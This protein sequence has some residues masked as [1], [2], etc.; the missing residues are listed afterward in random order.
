[1]DEVNQIGQLSQYIQEYGPFVV[2]LAVFLLL[3]LMIIIYFIKANK[4][5]TKASTEMNS[6][7]ITSILNDYMAKNAIQPEKKKLYDEKNIVDIFVKLNKSLKNVCETAS[8][9][10]NSD[11]TAIYV[12]HNGS[13]ASHGLPFFKMSCISEWVSKNSNSNIKMAEHSAMPL[14]LFDTIVS[15][16]YDDSQYR[17]TIGKNTD[18]G[19]LLF[20]KNTKI[21]DCIFIPIYDDENNMMGFVLNGY[22]IIIDDRNLENEKAILIELANMAKP[23]IEFSKCQDYKSTDEKE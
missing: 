21:K 18:P 14:N 23:V 6:K 4:D 20:L 2:I 5:A 8:K 17:I 11:R 3:F 19:D 1:M 22:N 15:G 7:L 16:L 12:F 9:K 10:S 13:H